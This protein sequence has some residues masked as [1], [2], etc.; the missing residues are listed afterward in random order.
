[1]MNYTVLVVTGYQKSTR[2]KPGQLVK[3]SIQFAD[4]G[5]FERVE[6]GKSSIYLTDLADGRLNSRL[7]KATKVLLSPRDCLRIDVLTGC[8]GVG[9]LTHLTGTWLY[10]LDPSVDVKEIR[11]PGIG[12]RDYPIAKGRLVEMAATTQADR[13]D[14]ERSQFVDDEGY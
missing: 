10:V 4:G 5:G 7:W 12:P 11:L 3:A 8:Q 9:A 1:M 6:S 2:R 13:L 14:D